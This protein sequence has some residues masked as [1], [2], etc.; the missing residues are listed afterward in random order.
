MRVVLA[1]FCL[2]LL[3]RAVLAQLSIPWWTVDAGGIANAAGGPFTLSG[4]A[5]Q[6]DASP[7]AM[8]GGTFSLTGGFWFV[9]P[10][11]ACPADLGIQGGSPGQDSHLDN[12]DFIA[13][14][15]LFF[16]AD[17]RADVGQQG[18]LPGHDG[19]FDNNDFIAFISHFF[20]GCG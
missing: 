3:P 12:N 17:A 14:I 15:S 20:A 6:I 4:T 19:Q 18:G 16:A 13:F 9:A 11:P 1:L 5:G 10:A 7:T 8:T 2:L